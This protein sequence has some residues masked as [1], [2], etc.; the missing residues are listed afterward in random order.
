MV[1]RNSCAS[2]VTN[3]VISN[4]FYLRTLD[5]TFANQWF[6]RHDSAVLNLRIAPTS[7]VTSRIFS[8]LPAAAI[9]VSTGTHFSELRRYSLRIAVV[10]WMRV[11]EHGDSHEIFERSCFQPRGSQFDPA[12]IVGNGNRDVHYSCRSQYRERAALVDGGTD[13]GLPGL[14]R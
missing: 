14:R 9:N 7:K 2:D 5:L 4:H 13:P 11:V 10:Q 3:M 12:A 6:I 8:P 1:G